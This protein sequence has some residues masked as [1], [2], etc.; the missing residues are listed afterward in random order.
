[1]SVTMNSPV[2]LPPR[3]SGQAKA[4]QS[5]IWVAMFAITMSF[6]AFTSA[7][8]IRQASADWTHLR[9]PRILFVNTALLLFSSVLLEMSRRAMLKKTGAAAQQIG[10]SKIL[11]SGALILGLMFIVGQYVAWQQLAAQGLYLA[12]NPNSSFFYLLTGM[13]ILHLAGGI[14]ALAYLLVHRALS[15]AVRPNLVNGVVTYWHFMAALWVYLLFII[16]TR[17]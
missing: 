8:V 4:S 12:T 14:I 9:T 7:L 13:H 2:M 10:R 6:A 16:I 15:G 11:L 3:G 1:M 17:L 5:G